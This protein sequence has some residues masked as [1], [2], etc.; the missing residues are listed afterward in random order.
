MPGDMATY[1]K[2][3]WKRF[4]PDYSYEATP[5][6][7]FSDVVFI[8]AVVFKHRHHGLLVVPFLD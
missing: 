6:K 7:F 8:L 3:M 4:S 1:R 5:G 2:W